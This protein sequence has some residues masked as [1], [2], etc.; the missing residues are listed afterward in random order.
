M[1]YEDPSAQSNGLGADSDISTKT[2][3]MDIT[4]DAGCVFGDTGGVDLMF[5]TV[6]VKLG[7]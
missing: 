2:Y 6:S 7:D 3:Q 1:D 5:V 4:S